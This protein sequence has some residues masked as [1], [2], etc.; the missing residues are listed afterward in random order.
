[1]VGIVKTVDDGNVVSIFT[2]GVVNKSRQGDEPQ[3]TSWV[4]VAS[5]GESCSPGGVEI[6]AND[7]HGCWLEVEI[8]SPDKYDE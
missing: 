1:M 3:I 5:K 4:F 6:L 7:A 2:N 8:T